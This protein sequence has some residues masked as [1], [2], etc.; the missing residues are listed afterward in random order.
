M[1]IIERNHQIEASAGR[2]QVQGMKRLRREDIDMAV[3]AVRTLDPLGK[4]RRI[5]RNIA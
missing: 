3:M 5:N 4:R 1:T 2:V